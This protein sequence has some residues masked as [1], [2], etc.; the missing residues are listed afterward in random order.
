M[1]EG[2]LRPS[3]AMV[4]LPREEEQLVEYDMDHQVHYI[5]PPLPL[6]CNCMMN[7]LREVVMG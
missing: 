2:T 6:S 1:V 5:A 4:D 3:Q 7:G